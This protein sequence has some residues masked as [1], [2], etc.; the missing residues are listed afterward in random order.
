MHAV[1]SMPSSG[2]P[3]TPMPACLTRI[4]PSRRR[5]CVPLKALCRRRS[6][7]CVT[8]QSE[9]LGSAGPRGK[10]CFCRRR[11]SSVT[12][13]PPRGWP[14]WPA[15]SKDLAHPLP[16][17]MP[18][19]SQPEDGDGLVEASRQYE[20]FGD[21]LAAADAAAQAVV[22]YQNAGLRG[23]AMTRVGHRPASG[24]RMPRRPDPRVTGRDDARNRSPPVSAR[25]Y[26]LPH[27]DYRTRRSPTG[28]PCRSAPSKDTSSAPPNA[29]EPTAANS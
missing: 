28:S 10:S 16:R 22:A 2:G 13:P 20:E 24:R 8:P 11:R 19:H 5:G 21:R 17:L 4:D 9:N 23:A 6:R 7:S 15:K 26:R 27:K 25:S 14:S 29:S 1:N 12:T 18:Q 3:K